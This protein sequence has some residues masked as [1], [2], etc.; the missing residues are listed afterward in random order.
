MT[1]R[2]IPINYWLK[3]CKVKSFDLN[4][5]SHRLLIICFWLIVISSAT[6][7]FILFKSYNTKIVEFEKNKEIIDD[8]EANF[9]LKR[10]FEDCAEDVKIFQNELS[11]TDGLINQY[12]EAEKIPQGYSITDIDNLINKLSN[13]FILQDHEVYYDNQEL[14]FAYNL[15]KQLGYVESKLV[16]NPNNSWWDAH[17][18]L[19]MFSSWM[20]VNWGSGGESFINSEMALNQNEFIM[21]KSSLPMGE[22]GCCIFWGNESTAYSDYYRFNVNLDNLSNED[23]LSISQ[24]LPH[25][26]SL[27]AYAMKYETM[28]INNQNMNFYPAFLIEPF[29]QISFFEPNG[30]NPYNITRNLEYFKTEIGNSNDIHFNS[31]LNMLIVVFVNI[32]FVFSIRMINWVNN[33]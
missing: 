23:A 25:E 29:E 30:F 5:K 11:S 6:S 24:N 2:E 9:A 26:Y 32:L 14:E 16:P 15:L 1:L 3:L 28:G 13:Q 12:F 27:D 4:R 7:F 33:G 18:L 31:I 10:F 19:Y 17:S 21:A 8:F 20:R 22:V